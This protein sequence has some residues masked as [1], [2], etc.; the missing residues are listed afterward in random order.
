MVTA[1]NFNDI[2]TMLRDM[3]LG[4]QENYVSAYAAKKDAAQAALDSIL[5]G[6]NT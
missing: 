4:E 5:E 2:S 1:F 3:V 6:A